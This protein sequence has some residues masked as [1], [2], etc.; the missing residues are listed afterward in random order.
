M[1][2]LYIFKL[3]F[4]QKSPIISGSLAE[5]DPQA[6]V[7]ASQGLCYRIRSDPRGIFCYEFIGNNIIF[8]I[9]KTF[10]EEPRTNKAVLHTSYRMQASTIG[11]SREKVPYLY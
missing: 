11:I 4:P 3:R 5:S 1:P 6:L 8:S 7:T 9:L 2:N 10:F